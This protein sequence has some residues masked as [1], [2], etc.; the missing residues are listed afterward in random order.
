[1]SFHGRCVRVCVVMK[2]PNHPGGVALIYK[3]NKGL[4][5]NQSGSTN[6]PVNP[7]LKPAGLTIQVPVVSSLFERYPKLENSPKKARALI[8]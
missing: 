1:M 2:P 5:E 7:V 8:G 4:T 6:K 3:K